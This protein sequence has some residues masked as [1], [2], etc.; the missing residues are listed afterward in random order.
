MPVLDAEPCY[1]GI[2][3]AGREDVQR[4]LFWACLLSGAAGHTYGANGLWQVNTPAQP[5][6]PSPHGRS[7]GDKPWQQAYQLPGSAQLG[8]ARA[9]LSHFPWWK[10]EPHPEW[11]E[12][13]WT[14]ENYILPYAGG[15]PGEVRVVYTPARWDLPKLVALERGTHRASLFDPVTGKRRD[16][17]PIT[18][19]DS[20]TW[21]PPV[22]PIVQDWVIVL[23][24][25]KAP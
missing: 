6:G 2:L 3:E 13:H 11:V 10:F 17:G 15:I 7:W 12:P 16:L 22:P 21:Q 9:F 25:A 1:E 24:H 23:E 18:V 5:Y 4:L 14:K 8:L 20:G 19:D